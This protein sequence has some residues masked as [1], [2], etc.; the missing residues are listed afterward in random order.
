M[1]GFTILD[2]LE[3]RIEK[4]QAIIDSRTRKLNKINDWVA[5]QEDIL[6]IKKRRL[7]KIWKIS[8]VGF[9]IGACLFLS[10]YLFINSITFILL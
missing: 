3:K 9:T 6:I 5:K 8:L 7:Q 1:S 2:S 4:V 10:I